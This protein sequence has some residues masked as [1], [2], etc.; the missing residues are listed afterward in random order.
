MPCECDDYDCLSEDLSAARA[1][2]RNLATG[3][4]TPERAAWWLAANYR[5]SVASDWPLRR[6][7]EAGGPPPNGRSWDEW[8]NKQ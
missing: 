4:T 5:D 8:F 6:L 2:I 3:L 1:M 7:A